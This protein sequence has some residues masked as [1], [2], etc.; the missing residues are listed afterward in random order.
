MGDVGLLHARTDQHAGHAET[1]TAIVADRVALVI[2]HRRE[3]RRHVIVEATPFVVVDDQQCP[4]PLRARAQRVVDLVQEGLSVAHVGERMI[5]VRRAGDFAAE[6]RVDVGHLRQLARRGIDEEAREG[7]ADRHEARAEQGCQRQVVEVVAAAQACRRQAIPDRRQCRGRRGIA[8]AI[9]LA[10]VHV[11]AVRVGAAENAAEVAV[12]DGPVLRAA[13]EERQI[14]G[15]EVADG[16]MIA[17]AVD[18]LQEA[19]V[20]AVVEV[21]AA[22]R[23]AV[24]RIALAAALVAVASGARKMEAVDGGAVL[25]GKAE[26]GLAS[27]R[28]GQPAQIMI[29]RAVLH[30]HD[31]DVV[32]AARLRVGQAGA[33]R[34]RHRACGRKHGRAAAAAAGR[35]RGDAGGRCGKAGEGAAA[36]RIEG[37]RRQTEFH[38]SV[39]T[40]KPT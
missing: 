32:D 10:R 31:D 18:G 22:A 24:V 2:G 6:A 9:G 15:A 11:H 37:C 16:K 5:V 7:L 40:G 8:V 21:H 12:A 3:R 14:V 36:G 1:Q 17:R 20:G 30:H 27:V 38:G 19:V 33:A 39:E 26:A 23:V 13:L 35:E 29:E 25:V 4:A 34:H 28:A